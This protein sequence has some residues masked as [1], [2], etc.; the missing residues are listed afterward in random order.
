MIEFY[1][2][3]KEDIDKIIYFILF[4]VLV[5]LF[6]K[7]IASYFAPFIFGYILCIILYPLTKFF[8]KKLKLPS[9][10]SSILTIAVLILL[11]VV[12]GIN[13]V[14]RVIEE[15][16]KF[17]NDIPYYIKSVIDLFNQWQEL[18]SK[19]FKILPEELQN[20]I[21]NSYDA[22]IKTL[23][24]I[25]GTGV[26]AGSVG[27]AKRLPNIIMIVLLGFISSFFLLK[28][29]ENIESFITRQ[30]PHSLKS[31][32]KAVKSGLLSGLSG[33]IRAQSILMC[34]ICFIC[35]IGLTILK[36]PY[37]LFLSILISF[38]DAL[39]VFGSGAFFWPW[40]IYCLATGD[41][42]RAI[43]IVI[44]NLTILITRQILEPRILGNQIGVHPL[45]TLM[46]I[47]IGLKVFGI[48]GFILGP[49]AVVTLKAMQDSDLLPRWK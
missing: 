44:I 8:N 15:G 32:I 42:K 4:A 47:Y 9:G 39:P 48:F 43:G 7:Y 29:K 46:S 21:N 45:V 37:A 14:S 2:K 33:Y 25:L 36:N 13:I 49:I 30:L 41:Y 16:K 11:F 3:N 1:R 22:I 5:Y 24:S 34:L 27:I 19:H 28:D 6:V 40:G 31:R 18:Y 10:I 38:V 26:K 12:L 17:S 23:T 35:F 20:A